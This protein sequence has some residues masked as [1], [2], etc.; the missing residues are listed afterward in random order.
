MEIIKQLENVRKF[1]SQ[2]TVAIGNFDGVH[3]GHRKIIREARNLAGS[4]KIGIIT[5]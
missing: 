5:F 1:T 2:S 4:N 3:L